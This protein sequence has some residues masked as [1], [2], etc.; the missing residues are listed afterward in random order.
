MTNGKRVKSERRTQC[1]R[2]T[3]KVW[4]AAQKKGEPISWKKARV[5]GAAKL[6]RQAG[7]GPI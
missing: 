6:F 4:R 3:A 5:E 7:P 2:Y 1:D